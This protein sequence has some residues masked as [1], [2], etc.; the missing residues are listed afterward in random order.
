MIKTSF[1]PVEVD[2][3]VFEKLIV[4]KKELGNPQVMK[5]EINQLIRRLNKYK[6]KHRHRVITKVIKHDREK[7]TISIQILLPVTCENNI[8]TFLSDYDGYYYFLNKYSLKQ[9]ILISIPNEM[10]AFK[11][12]VDVFVQYENMNDVYDLDIKNN[13]IIEIAKVDIHG[14]ILGFDLH[15]EKRRVIKDVND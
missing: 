4:F 15:I 7:K 13:H 1:E 9:S 11:R 8:Q 12:A 3:I 5:K 10:N 2:N 6:I 14:T